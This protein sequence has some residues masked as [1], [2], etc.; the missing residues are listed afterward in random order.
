MGQFRLYQLNM[1]VLYIISV[2]LL[3]KTGVAS[4][5]GKSTSELVSI[6]RFN[7][8]KSFAKF[9][10]KFFGILSLTIYDTI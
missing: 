4:E 3:S 5:F 9:S 2:A 1:L 6:I 8:D 7:S 10:G